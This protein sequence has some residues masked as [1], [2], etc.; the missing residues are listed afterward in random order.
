MSTPR[1]ATKAT[2]TQN[3]ASSSSIVWSSALESFGDRG[4][5]RVAVGRSDADEPLDDRGGGLGRDAAHIDHRG[6][7]GRRDA[8]LRLRDAGIELRIERLAPGFCLGS[9]PLAGIV[10]Q[11]LGAAARVGQRLF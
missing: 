8:A 9:L 6:R 2:A 10:D 11:G 4:L 3:S 7:L 5:E 1:K